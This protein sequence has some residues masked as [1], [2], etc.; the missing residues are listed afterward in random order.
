MKRISDFGQ[1]SHNHGSTAQISV[2][3]PCFPLHLSRDARILVKLQHT[4]E[5]Q[6]TIAGAFTADD[7]QDD[8][9]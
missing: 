4:H 9:K 3:S 7:N 5:L 6:T 8:F 1:H 2:P